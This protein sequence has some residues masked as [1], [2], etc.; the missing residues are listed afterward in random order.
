MTDETNFIEKNRN[1]LE[2]HFNLFGG[3]FCYHIPDCRLFYENKVGAYYIP[4]NITAKKLQNIIKDDIANGIDT[5]SEKFKD[6]K[7]INEPNI[8]Y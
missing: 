7:I 5:I 8:L 1:I 2:Q 3:H 6:N 4:N